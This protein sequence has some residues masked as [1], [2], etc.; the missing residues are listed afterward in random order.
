MPDDQYDLVVIGSGPAGQKAAIRAAKLR[1]RVAVADRR[2]RLGGT[3]LH[4]SMIPS[5]T[6]RETIVRRAESGTVCFYPSRTEYFPA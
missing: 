1:K 6:L 4:T 3:S 5:K 2:H